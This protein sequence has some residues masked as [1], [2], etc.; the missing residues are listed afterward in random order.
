MLIR[1]SSGQ[2]HETLRERYERLLNDDEVSAKIGRGMLALLD[3]L[4]KRL[5]EKTVWCHTSHHWLCFLPDDEA[6]SA[7]LQV[8]GRDEDYAI[9]YRRVGTPGAD[10]RV[11]VHGAA[12]A[13]DQ[14]ELAMAEC[15][16][17][18]WA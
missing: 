8:I 6:K 11:E 10:V 16:G 13:A 9:E 17:W 14:L 7:P 3:E 2:Q 12:Q 4:A 18:Q 1:K 15:W 5:P